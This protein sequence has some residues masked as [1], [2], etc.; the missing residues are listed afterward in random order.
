MRTH[1][2]LLKISIL[3]LAMAAL[4]GCQRFD[5]SR[6]AEDVREE[7]AE[8]A[9]E[10]AEAKA[11]AAQG[12]RPAASQRAKDRGTEE[13]PIISGKLTLSDAVTLA[14]ANN[15]TLQTAY[16]TRTEADGVIMQAYAGALPKADASA[17]AQNMWGDGNDDD[18]YSLGVEIA[19]PL[20]RSGAIGAAIRYARLYAASTDFTIREQV[21]STVYKVVQ[22]Y[23]TVLLDQHLVQ[24]YED[25]NAVSERLLQTTRNRREQGTVSDYEVLRAGVEV[26]NTKAALINAN[27]VLQSDIVSLFREM[28]VSQDSTVDFSGELAYSPEA[29]DLETASIKALRERPDIARAQ[30]A[31]F[32]TEENIKIANSSYGP[33]VDAFASG[34]Y[35]N[36]RE[37]D[38]NDEWIIGARATLSL[39][40]GFERRGKVMAAVSKRDQAAEALR[41]I[42]DLAHVEV[43]DALLKL[44]YAEELYISQMKNLDLS[45]EALRI[46]ETGS[47]FGRNTQVEVLDARAALTQSVGTYYNAV[48]SHGIA[49]LGIRYAT[50]TLSPDDPLEDLVVMP[51]PEQT[52]EPGQAA[53][54]GQITA[55]GSAPGQN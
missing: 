43:V 45:K 53:E 54:P 2:Q 9:K 4:A 15:R 36:R 35:S 14:M 1:F 42:E 29:Y 18:T 11:E 26:A 20:W 12:P 3:P 24:V 5:S 41:D 8:R 38:W 46:L 33:K 49:R 34:D 39:F 23:M 6:A 44:K 48:Y 13:L 50:G 30:A 17:A 16:L 52:P 47:S 55:P 25:A 22:K 10:R 32:M 7:L 40:D 37:D 28:G 21:Q 31:L 19:Q 27:N 51:E